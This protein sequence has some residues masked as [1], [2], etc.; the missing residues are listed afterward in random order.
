M[1]GIMETPPSW[2]EASPPRP[3]RRH[4]RPRQ[5]H[6]SIHHTAPTTSRAMEMKPTFLSL[7]S[8]HQFAR[9]DH[10]DPY[11]YLSNF[12]DLCGTMGIPEGDE[13]AIYLRL[14]PFSLT[15]KA[16]TWLQSHPNQ[17]LISWS[18]V[19]NKFVNRI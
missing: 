3:L 1:D 11:A 8:A 13:E 2:V 19:E 6:R 7:V 5:A 12:Y 17:S 9:M 16:K 10:E 18:D 15:G 14:F 4:N